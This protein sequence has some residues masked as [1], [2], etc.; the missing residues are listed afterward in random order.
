MLRRPLLRVLDSPSWS[1]LP[2]KTSSSPSALRWYTR[3]PAARHSYMHT[4][5][6]LSTPNLFSPCCAY[7]I[8]WERTCS[9]NVES[10]WVVQEGM[11]AGKGITLFSGYRNSLSW[12]LQH[13]DRS[14][15]SGSSTCSHATSSHGSVF[16]LNSS[17]SVKKPSNA[18]L[19]RRHTF[20]TRT[21]VL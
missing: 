6:H 17:A 11:R 1:G 4:G 20:D 14:R 15:P 2:S 9:P 12:Y 21:C 5:A 3:L 19:T 13:H 8:G 10:G 7:H 16:L 18:T